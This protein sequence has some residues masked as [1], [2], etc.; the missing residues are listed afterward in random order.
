[1]EAAEPLLAAI[2]SRHEEQ[3]EAAAGDA[4]SL[5]ALKER[6]ERELKRATTALYVTGLEI[7]AGFYRDA[8]AAQFGAAP[9]NADVP[10]T[11][12]TQVRP[13]RALTAAARVL[14]TIDALHSNQRPHLAFAA[15]FS[16]LGDDG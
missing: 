6:Q 7:L 5:R 2:R 14:D 13:A 11:A 1:M 12:F 8:A 16:D 15:L 3:Q 10:V 4:G 9:R